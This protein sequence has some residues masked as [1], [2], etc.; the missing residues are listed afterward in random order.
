MTLSSKT[1]IA[2]VPP[3][4]RPPCRR[5]TIQLLQPKVPLYSTQPQTK[6]KTN[7]MNS[8]TISKSLISLASMVLCT[9][10]AFAQQTPPPPAANAP[11]PPAAPVERQ[12][13]PRPPMRPGMMRPGMMQQQPDRSE[14]HTSELQSLRHLVG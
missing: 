11:A 13:P 4:C 2:K 1:S 5:S 6:G 3:P 9:S 14:E 12:A 7:P 10:L 8:R